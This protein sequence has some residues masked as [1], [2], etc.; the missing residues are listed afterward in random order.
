MVNLLLYLKQ[1]PAAQEP[2]LSVIFSSSRFL[3]TNC[4]CDGVHVIDASR[5]ASPCSTSYSVLNGRAAMRFR[6]SSATGPVVTNRR[7]TCLIA[8]LLVWVFLVGALNLPLSIFIGT[9]GIGK[10]L[11]T[12]NND[13]HSLTDVGI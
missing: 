12:G 3:R 11:S 1:N 7:T 5:L 6:T 13:I 4:S 8:R 2:E 10:P 9:Y